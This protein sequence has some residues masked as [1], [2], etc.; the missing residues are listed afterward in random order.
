MESKYLKAGNTRIYDEQDNIMG[1]IQWI[2]LSASVEYPFWKVEY[3]RRRTQT[4]GIVD[5]LYEAHLRQID[6]AKEDPDAVGEFDFS[7]DEEPGYIEK[8][9]LIRL[10]VSVHVGSTP[11]I[12]KKTTFADLTLEEPGLPTLKFTEQ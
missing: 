10:G 6:F 12:S 1:H 7:K 2:I 5:D 3:A 9:V 8:Q 4:S 11:V